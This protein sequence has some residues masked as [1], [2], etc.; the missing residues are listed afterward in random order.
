MKDER[1]QQRADYTAVNGK[2]RKPLIRA[3]QT[4]PEK[5]PDRPLFAR[6]RGKYDVISARADY[7]ERQTYND[8]IYYEIA[9]ESA[10]LCREIRARTQ[11]FR[12]LL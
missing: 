7:S 3:V 9:F 11:L 12:T 10:T 6:Q 8:K 5:L 1:A 2:P 4:E